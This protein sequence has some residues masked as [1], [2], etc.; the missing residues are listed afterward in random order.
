MIID[1]FEDLH[2]KDKTGSCILESLIYFTKMAWSQVSLKEGY[3]ACTLGRIDFTNKPAA[4]HHVRHSWYRHRSLG[5]IG[6]YYHLP[7]IKFLK[8]GKISP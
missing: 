1:V 6:G 5:Y 4:V 8:G 3:Q 7:E 2:N